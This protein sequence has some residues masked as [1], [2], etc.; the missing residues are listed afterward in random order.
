MSKNTIELGD[1]VKDKITGFEGIC[2]QHVTY[3]NGCDRI[4][5]QPQSL[6]EGKPV[7]AHY[8]DIMQLEIVE[9]A[10]QKR[11]ARAVKTGGATH[12]IPAPQTPKR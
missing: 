1:K 12:K 3:L 2:I 7:E 8:F 11:D 5:V 6:H 4:C 10:S 9:K